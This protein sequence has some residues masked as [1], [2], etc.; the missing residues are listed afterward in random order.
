MR[1]FLHRVVSVFLLTTVTLVGAARAAE[2]EPDDSG[3]TK[4]EPFAF[5]DFTWLTGNPRTTVSPLSNDV[6]TFEFRADVQFT[7]DFNK[8]KDDTIVGSSEIFRHNEIQ[9]TMLGVG[10]DLHWKNVR[11]RL[12][13]QFGL[14]SQTT[15]ERREHGPRTVAA[16]RCLPLHLGGPAGTTS[17]STGSTSTPGSS[18]LRRPLQLLPVRRWAYQPS[19]V[20]SNTP[21]FFNGIGSRSSPATS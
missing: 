3:D 13:T 11:G 4:R 16:R 12:M 2:P 9:L 7:Y 17:S 15:P 1:P 10:G 5:A 18:V 8:P 6:F 19:Y 21:W 20:S 14:Y